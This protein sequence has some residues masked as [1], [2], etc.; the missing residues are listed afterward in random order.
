MALVGGGGRC[1]L[2]L[3]RL[4]AARRTEYAARLHDV[5]KIAVPKEIINKPG[6][7]GS[8][9]EWDLMRLHTVEGERMLGRVGG[10][11]REVGAIVRGSARTMGRARLPGRNIWRG[12]HRSRLA[13]SP[14]PTP[15]TRWWQI[16]VPAVGCRGRWLWRRSCER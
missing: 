7:A 5:G 8:W 15:T 16:T 13:S 4:A 11:L 6:P 14:S 9:R 2:G 10:A 3:D 1:E 12:G